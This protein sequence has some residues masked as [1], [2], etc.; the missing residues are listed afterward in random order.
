M[1]FTFRAVVGF[2]CVSAVAGVIVGYFTCQHLFGPVLSNTTV[3]MYSARLI[4]N[5]ANLAQVKRNNIACVRGA[6]ESS[7][8]RDLEQLSFFKDVAAT[9]PRTLKVIETSGAMAQ[10]SLAVA[11]QNQRGM[12]SSCR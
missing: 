5:S 7:V 1:L 9:D 6:L 4:E 12:P 3:A 11:D 2:S 8:R 10:E